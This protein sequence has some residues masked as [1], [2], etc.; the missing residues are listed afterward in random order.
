MTDEKIVESDIAPPRG[1]RDFYGGQK[2]LRDRVLSVLKRVFENYSFNALETPAFENYSVLSAKFAGGEE[3]LKETYRLTD[4]GGRGLG[5]RYDLTVPLCRFVAGNPSL[6]KPFK[7]YAIG[8]VWRDGPLKT[9]RYREFTQADV[10]TIGVEGMAADAEILCLTCEAL[11]KLGLDFS[12]K[13]NNRK[14]LDGLL[15]QA[16]VA[17]EKW[18]SALQSLDKLVKI[19]EAGVRRE[20]LG[21][22]GLTATQVDEL[23]ELISAEKVGDLSNKVSN[24]VGGQGISELKRLFEFLQAFGCA[25]RVEFDASLARGL[26]YYTSTVFEAFLS[27]ELQERAGVSSSIAAGGRYDELVGKFVEEVSGRREQMPAVGISFGVDVLCVALEK[28]GEGKSSFADGKKVFVVPIKEFAAGA[29]I[30]QR[31]RSEGIACGIDLLERGISKNLEYA[32]KQGFSYALIVGKQE[33]SAGKVKLRNLLSGEEKMLSI[34]A[35]V[36]L[37]KK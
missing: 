11:A 5:L 4:Q 7:R 10:D 14:L 16:G 18:V 29:E 28:I 6:P 27:P 3:I 21:G 9:G 33:L 35:A 17:Q 37:L 13:V 34:E 32:G 19:G 20:L 8:S 15:A 22:K 2:Q 23:F 31:L 30:C 26:N 1:T 36:A 25:P 12:I 24:E